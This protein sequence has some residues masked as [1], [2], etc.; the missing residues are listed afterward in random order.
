MSI[1]ETHLTA[2]TDDTTC[3]TV[4][5]SSGGASST[6][7]KSI[8]C[9]T[10]VIIFGYST[11]PSQGNP[12]GYWVLGTTNVAISHQS[13]DSGTAQARSVERHLRWRPIQDQ[14]FCGESLR[15]GGCPA[16]MEGWEQVDY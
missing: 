5:G 4:H 1:A 2:L 16:S 12:V 6:A 11:R 8:N 14:S 13:D 9:T 15:G 3:N 10:S 7:W